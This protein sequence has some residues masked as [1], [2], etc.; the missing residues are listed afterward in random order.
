MDPELVQ[1]LLQFRLRD[2]LVSA[3]VEGMLL[4]MGAHLHTRKESQVTRE[5]WEVSLQGWGG[6]WFLLVACA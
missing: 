1:M 3:F 5:L 2:I 6:G 4:D